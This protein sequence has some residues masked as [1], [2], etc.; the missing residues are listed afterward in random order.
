MDPL[1]AFR[2][3]F[4]RRNNRFVQLNFAATRSDLVERP[5]G[6]TNRSNGPPLSYATKRPNS[7]TG[8]V[9]SWRSNNKQTRLLSLHYILSVHE[10]QQASRSLMENMPPR[11]TVKAILP[12]RLFNFPR[13]NCFHFRLLCFSW[14]PKNTAVVVCRYCETFKT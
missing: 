8:Q 6:P 14:L 12:G 10:H 9:S 3:T 11:R 5:S 13:L 4:E 2:A 7:K 1:K